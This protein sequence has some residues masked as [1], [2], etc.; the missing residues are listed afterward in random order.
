MTADRERTRRFPGTTTAR[1]R[2]RPDFTTGRLQ[3]CAPD[4]RDPARRDGVAREQVRDLS[5]TARLPEARSSAHDLP[6]AARRT[7]ERERARGL[8]ADV[9]PSTQERER[10]LLSVERRLGLVATRRAFMNT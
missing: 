1:E 4:L 2:V 10:D 3:N 5:P 7:T 8:A 9:R 6:L